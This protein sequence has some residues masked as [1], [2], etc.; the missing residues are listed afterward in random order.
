MLRIDGKRKRQG[1][2]HLRVA[3]GQFRAQMHYRIHIYRK[4]VPA[5]QLGGLALLA[6]KHSNELLLLQLS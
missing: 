5:V 3:C 6:N 4:I 2:L 1:R